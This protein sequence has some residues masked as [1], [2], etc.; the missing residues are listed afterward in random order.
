M[1]LFA[2]DQE[3]YPGINLSVSQ[4]LHAVKR[5]LQ[6]S[7]FG[8]GT[9]TGVDYFEVDR[10]ERDAFEAL[11]FLRSIKNTFAPIHRIPSEI[12]SLVPR[13]WGEGRTDS[14]LIALTHVCRRW[15]KVFTASSALWTHLEC[16]DVEKTRVYV[17][18]SKSSPLEV[19]LSDS[20]KSYNYLKAAFLL[21]IPHIDRVMS[22][23]IIGDK[24]LFQYFTK[25]FSCPLPLL[26]HLTFHISSR[27]PLVL[28]N[29]LFNGDLSSLRTLTLGGV[30]PHLP[31]NNLPQLTTFTLLSF[32]ISEEISVTRL[33]D[34]FSNTP[35]L[36]KIELQMVPR[37]SDAPPG[38]VVTLPRLE[39]FIARGDLGHTSM[40]LDHLPIPAGALLDL[41]FPL[42]GVESPLP[43]ILLKASENLQNILHITSAYLDFDLEYASIRL[44]GPSGKL[45][46]R[47]TRESW[48]GSSPTTL[49]H[50]LFRS[51][52]CLNT[53]KIQR[54]AVT[55]LR[56]YGG[57]DKSTCPDFGIMDDLRT[58][59][60]SRCSPLSLTLDPNW[61]PQ[62]PVPCPK[63][64]KL[65]FYVGDN[66]VLSIRE[67]TIMARERALKGASLRSIVVISGRKLRLEGEE[68]ELM[69]YVERF[70]CRVGE[71]PR[72][73]QIP[74]DGTN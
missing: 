24:D 73:D 35:L 41:E 34:I 71:C 62:E 8:D 51:L 42:S 59:F 29:T 37:L 50:A 5:K 66:G 57:Q 18:R 72:W 27:Q 63:L 74:D 48:F 58:L 49:G 26:R 6:S 4:L 60:L 30:M 69:K 3:S 39:S 22:V 67:V 31:S 13:Y 38:R 44:D 16:N 33:L 28:S 23:E 61:K 55:G 54:L 19:V 40:I 2:D 10:L 21:V 53:S 56:I 46:M 25:H 43:K 15:R 17:E 52:D 45:H 32:D 9:S 20:K 47:G 1:P 64:E 7:T 65:V 12:L 36:R 70:E 11:S 68:F 14:D